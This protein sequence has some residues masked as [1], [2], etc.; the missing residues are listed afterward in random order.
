MDEM[1]RK[2][3]QKL[4]AMALEEDLDGLGDITSAAISPQ[5][6]F[7][8]GQFLVKADGVISGLDIVTE[9]FKTVDE[10]II[11]QPATVDGDLVLKGQIAMQVHGPASS[12]LIA[13]RTALNF[14]CRLSGIAS[15]TR[16]YVD[17]LNGTRAK[18]LDTRK[19]TPGW[20]VLEKYAV[21]CGGGVNHRM[22]LYDM[23]LI[24][25]NHIAAAGSISAAVHQCRVYLQEHQ[26]SSPI[27]VETRTLPEVEE[28]LE[29][30]V[31]RIMLDNMGLELMQRCVNR[32]AGQIPLEASGNIT[33]ATI[34]P[35]AETGVDFISSGSLT[36]SA[37]I[38]DLS[39]DLLT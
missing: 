30:Q 38:L 27:E 15:L 8:H 19:T 10:T 7:A 36:H 2:Q 25:D 5:Q 29:L 34:R 13:E 31:D 14:L 35:V 26:L 28:A 24:K 3:A 1:V 39:L 21:R 37:P 4:I 18:L 32:V 16:K 20:R 6:E 33:L 9:V 22:G 11:C 23:V 17:L 12:L